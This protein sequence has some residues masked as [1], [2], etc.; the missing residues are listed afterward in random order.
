MQTGQVVAG[1]APESDSFSFEHPV[2]SPRLARRPAQGKRELNLSIDVRAM[3]PRIHADLSGCYDLS[4]TVLS[5]FRARAGQHPPERVEEPPMRCPRCQSES[6]LKRKV[7][8]SLGYGTFHCRNCKRRFTERTGQ[9]FNDL[10][11]PTSIVLMAVPWRL[12]Y[13]LRFRDVAELLLQRGFDVSHET[14]RTWEYRFAPLVSERLRSRG[15]GNAGRCWYLDETWVRVRGR[16][17]YL[18]RA[19]DRDG[20]LLDSM[21]SDHRDRQAARRFLRRLLDAASQRPLRLTT[22]RH[23]AY[24]KAI[25]WTIGRK[26]VHRQSQYLNNCMKQSHRPIRQRFYP[27]L[28]FKR[29]DSASRFCAAFDELRNYLRNGTTASQPV[30]S[31]DRRRT[32]QT[33]WSA[34]LAELSA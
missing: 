5:G 2:L 18:Y 8:T 25:H 32:F 10:Q 23:P 17:C 11:F 13:K 33:R 3:L 28:G 21:L 15:R 19:I 1:E 14:I 4:W 24:A 34:L 31:S 16:W 7:R 6:I 22:D 27:M 30:T 9:P 12:R 26:T 20:S 29:F